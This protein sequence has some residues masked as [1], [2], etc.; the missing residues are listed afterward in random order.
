ML[1]LR[2]PLELREFIDSVRGVHCRAKYIIR[3]VSYVRDNCVD[4]ND[5]YENKYE[6]IKIDVE[7]GENFN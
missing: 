5:Y 6:R 4:V 2:L 7:K 3:C 1:N